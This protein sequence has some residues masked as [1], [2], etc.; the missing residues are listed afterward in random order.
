MKPAAWREQAASALV[1]VWIG[2][3]VLSALLQLL[4]IA[5]FRRRVAGGH[6][7]PPSL[8]ALVGDVASNL[9]V[10]PPPIVVMSDLASPMLW[11]F[12]RARFC[13]RRPCWAS[14]AG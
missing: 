5:R 1:A 2:G 13:G 11:S 12:G 7:A 4:R 3:V 8:V 9:G 14:C 10:R 6:A